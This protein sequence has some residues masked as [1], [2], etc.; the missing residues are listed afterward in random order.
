[1]NNIKLVVVVAN[2]GL[3]QHACII[4]IDSGLQNNSAFTIPKT[5][6]TSIHMEG[7]KNEEFVKK[8]YV[9]T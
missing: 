5:I 1:M 6:H 3:V 2:V 9:I 4:F 8:I 7:E